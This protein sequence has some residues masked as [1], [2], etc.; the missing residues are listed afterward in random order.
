MEDRNEAVLEGN[1]GRDKRKKNCTFRKEGKCVG[2][3]VVGLA[4]EH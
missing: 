1:K 3:V 4:F 2:F